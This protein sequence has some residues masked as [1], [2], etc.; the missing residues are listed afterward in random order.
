MDVDPFELER[1]FAEYEH[2]ADVM[3]AESGVRSV[4]ADRFDTDPGDLGYV[5]PTDGAPDV[6]EAIAADYGRSA[7]E[8]LCTVGTQEANF[9]AFQSLLSPGDHAV[10]VTPTYQSLHAVPDSICD[11]TRVPLNEPEWTLDVDA[12]ADAIRPE[13]ELVVVNNPNNPTGRKHSKGAMRALYDV[14]AANDA[15]L[16]GD[17]VY[18]LLAED[19]VPPVASMGEYGISTASNTIDRI[20]YAF[21]FGWLAGPAEVVAAA[22]RWKD[23][24]TIS[25][26][27]FGQHVARQVLD[28]EEESLRS[29]ALEH[30]RENHEITAEWAR[31]HGLDWPD[32]VGCNVFLRVPAGFEDSRAFCRTVVEGAGVV[33]APGDCFS[34]GGE[35]Y[36]DHFRLGFGLPTDELREGLA[37][38][39]DVL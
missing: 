36:D 4:P 17:E 5:I 30:V 32:P 3:L 25:P 8:V 38:V 11:V 12:V 26:S 33:L 18:R 29:A 24:T 37:R 23:Y 20:A 10:V 34:T 15:Y 1:W 16:L 35:S 6:R 21:R 9:L 19:P 22:E 27:K 2:D 7:D 31:G 13:T 14:A 39:D 28:G